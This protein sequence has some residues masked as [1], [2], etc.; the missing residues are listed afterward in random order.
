MLHL[1]HEGAD[2]HEASATDPF[3]ISRVSG[4]G[5]HRGVKSGPLVLHYVDGLAARQRRSHADPP[6]PVWRLLA[7]LF[8][9]LS[10]N[11]LVILT[12]VGT[13]LEITVLHCVEQGLV[14]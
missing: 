7:T 4:I 12:K 2:Q 3:E 9:Q 10:E 1:V 8:A 13:E 6:V 5:H 11:P 14:Q